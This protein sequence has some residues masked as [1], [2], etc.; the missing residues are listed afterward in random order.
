MSAAADNGSGG[1]PVRLTPQETQVLVDQGR[2]PLSTFVDADG[3]PVESEALLVTVPP[4][5]APAPVSLPVEYTAAE[6]EI[7]AEGEATAFAIQLE[8]QQKRRGLRMRLAEERAKLANWWRRR[9]ETRRELER[10]RAE[11]EAFL[12]PLP[13]RVRRVLKRR[14]GRLVRWVPWAMWGADTMFLSRAYG[15][16]GEVPLPF[17][18]SVAVTNMTQVLRA[19]LVSFG[20]VFGV[21]LLGAKLRD[22]VE[23]LRERHAAVGLLADA[24]VG[25]LVLVGAV[26]LAESAAQI[27]Q[28]LLQIEAGGSSVQLPT[29]VLFSIVAFLASVSLACGYYLSEPEVE[30]AGDHERRVEVAK[31]AYEAA[32]A[33]CHTQLGVV[34]A[35]REELRSLDEEE[36]LALAE[37]QAHSDRRV[38]AH[39][40]GNTVIY[41]L[42]PALAPAS[43]QAGRHGTS[44]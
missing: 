36:T 4:T 14:W 26:R 30:Q 5:V 12:T 42:G 18:A 40:A 22:L 21:R 34:R 28:A 16:F 23:E 11:Q 1:G 13:R 37:N 8:H 10:E 15:L 17:S 27:Q 9:S 43:A 20:L 3:R 29:S 33:A 32:A 44:P 25:A 41:G 31:A 39:K 19:G 6:L 38:W 2:R 35:A 24:G 7:R